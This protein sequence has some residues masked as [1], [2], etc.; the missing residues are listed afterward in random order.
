MAIHF[1]VCENPENKRVSYSH[2]K[3]VPTRHEKKREDLIL[4]TFIKVI[5]FF[6]NTSLIIQLLT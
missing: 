3:A 4:I 5:V 2:T 1:A 6:D